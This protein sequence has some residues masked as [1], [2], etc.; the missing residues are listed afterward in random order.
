LTEETQIL[1]ALDAVEL[2]L[3]VWYWEQ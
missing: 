3:W 1:D 2:R